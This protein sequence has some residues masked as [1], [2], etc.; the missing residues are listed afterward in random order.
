MIKQVIVDGFNYSTEC[1][2]NGRYL[3]D[4]KCR[5]AYAICE[6]ATALAEEFV[7]RDD[8]NVEVVTEG[9]LVRI[10]FD[11]K[12]DIELFACYRIDTYPNK[13]CIYLIK[14]SGLIDNVNPVTKQI[15]NNYYG[16]TAKKIKDYFPGY[17]YTFKKKEE[18]VEMKTKTSFPFQL[19]HTNDSVVVVH[20]NLDDGITTLK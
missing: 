11:N 14:R 13:P 18:D 12:S 7:D 15:I 10:E 2:V 6:I 20:F 9:S 17:T 16:R 19:A 1:T 5:S 8:V 3:F 4:I